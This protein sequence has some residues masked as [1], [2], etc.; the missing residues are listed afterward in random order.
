[1]PAGP[2][3]IHGY[4]TADTDTKYTVIHYKEKLEGKYEVADTEN[5]TGVTDEEALAIAKSYP[6]FTWDPEVAGT[7]VTGII[8][9]DGTLE[10]RLYYNRNIHAVTYGY[11]GVVPDGASDLP[12]SRDY[13][14]GEVVN[15]AGP[16]SAPGYDFSGW[17]LTEGFTMP[18]KNVE[19]KGH[20]TA[21]NDTIYTVEH[22]LQDLDG[23]SYTREEAKEWTGITGATATAKP[24]T[25]KG[26]TFDG[27]VEGTVQTGTIT[28]DGKLVLKLFYTRNS[29]TVT[30]NYEGKVP[31]GVTALP[32]AETYKYGEQVKEIG[33]A[34]V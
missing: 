7:K 8:E 31:T 6:G 26:F 25:Y 11:E 3:Y 16:A 28:G 34:H 2:V 13:K 23:N 18:D 24:N 30:Y 10:L 19:I 1:M 21:R 27:S 17:S 29:H 5:L 22:Y 33:R 14:F 9:A 4:F 20:F 15:I 32:S 12:A